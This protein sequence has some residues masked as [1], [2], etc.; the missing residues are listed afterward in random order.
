MNKCSTLNF[1]LNILIKLQGHPQSKHKCS[2]V[3]TAFLA[4]SRWLRILLWK[5]FFQGNPDPQF[6]FSWNFW[7]HCV[8]L[9]TVDEVP[10]KVDVSPRIN[11]NNC[12]NKVYLIWCQDTLL[13]K[14]IKQPSSNDHTRNLESETS[15]TMRDNKERRRNQK[16][17]PM[18]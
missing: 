17:I 6:L 4:S 15:H 16:G 2:Q 10:L 12:D 7:M 3:S 5:V 11:P 1:I 8:L 13:L 9:F 14:I 18:E